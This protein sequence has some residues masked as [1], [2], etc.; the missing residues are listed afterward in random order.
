MYYMVSDLFDR[1]DISVSI[2]NNFASI[3]NDFKTPIYIVT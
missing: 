3:L 2:V 1:P